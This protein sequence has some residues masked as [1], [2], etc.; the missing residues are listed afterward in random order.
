MKKAPCIL[1]PLNTFCYHHHHHHQ[2]RA[3]SVKHNLIYSLIIVFDGHYA[4][5]I[6]TLHSLECFCIFRLSDQDFVF[7][8]VNMLHALSVHF[9]ALVIFTAQ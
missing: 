1:M 3:V 9:I 4:I 8:S 5:L 2:N 6:I 7:I